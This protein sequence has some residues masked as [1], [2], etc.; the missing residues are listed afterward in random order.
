M[1]IDVIRLA[2]LVAERQLYAVWQ[3]AEPGRRRDRLENALIKANIARA[4]LNGM[5]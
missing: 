3:A 5:R 4:S 2:I 1:N